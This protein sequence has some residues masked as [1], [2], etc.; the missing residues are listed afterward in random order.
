MPS[1]SRSAASTSCRVPRISIIELGSSGADAQHRA[2]E[3]RSPPEPDE[4]L[5][6][7]DAKAEPASVIAEL[8][9]DG[10]AAHQK[11]K[12]AATRAWFRRCSRG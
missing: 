7:M 9:R 11:A 6:T 3:L 5:L 2:A 12:Q 10:S 8:R 4:A 1:C